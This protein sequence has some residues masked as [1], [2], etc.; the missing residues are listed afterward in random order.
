MRSNAG[1]VYD[2]AMGNYFYRARYYNQS[3]GR[4]FSR[5][6]IMSLASLYAYC[7]NS[8]MNFTDPFGLIESSSIGLNDMEVSFDGGPAAGGIP[9]AVPGPWFWWDPPKCTGGASGSWGYVGGGLTIAGGAGV[10][11]LA[12][13]AAATAPVWVTAVGVGV[14]V[15][16]VGAGVCWIV[17]TATSDGMTIPPDIQQQF[18]EAMARSFQ[19]NPIEEMME[20]MLSDFAA[21]LEFEQRLIRNIQLSADDLSTGNEGLGLIGSG[22]GNRN[23]CSCIPDWSDYPD[24]GGGSHNDMK[25]GIGV[26]RLDSGIA[27]V[28]N[29]VVAFAPML[30]SWCES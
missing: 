5:D 9:L 26:Q 24:Q 10:I 28:G 2:G 4:F 18:W 20:D 30:H 8:P 23:G 1:R 6:P 22:P 15:C 12:V 25:V 7:H 29:S 19:K 16:T 11:A 21:R 3:L 13:G 14:G 27:A 17:Q